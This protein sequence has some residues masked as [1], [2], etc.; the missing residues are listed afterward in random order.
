MHGW[1]I[2]RVLLLIM[3]SMYLVSI[4]S[5]VQGVSTIAFVNDNFMVWLYSRFLCCFL[6]LCELDVWYHN[7][8]SAKFCVLYFCFRDST[9][10]FESS[11]NLFTKFLQ[12]YQTRNSNE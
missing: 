6:I 3:I 10:S 11:T 2:L 5:A 4:T 7:P 9:F 12:L 1:Y 8:T